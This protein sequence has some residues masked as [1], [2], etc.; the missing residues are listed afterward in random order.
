MALKRFEHET[1]REKV[2]IMTVHL[3]ASAMFWRVLHFICGELHFYIK[4]EKICEFLSLFP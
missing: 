4:A 3:A 2:E 1:V